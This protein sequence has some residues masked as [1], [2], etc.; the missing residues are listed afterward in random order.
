MFLLTAAVLAFMMFA[1]WFSCSV[2]W[3][4][5][6]SSRFPR[7]EVTDASDVWTFE[8]AACNWPEKT[9][10]M[11]WIDFSVASR[12][13]RTSL[14][15]LSVVESNA[16]GRRR[17]STTLISTADSPTTIAISVI[18][19]PRPLRFHSAESELSPERTLAARWPDT[20]AGTGTTGNAAPVWLGR[21]PRRCRAQHLRSEGAPCPAG[22]PSGSLPH[23]RRLAG[24][25]A[26]DRG[27]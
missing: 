18:L 1:L 10:L 16:R 14:R 26:R 19:S 12:S 11:F 21:P 3:R 4:L 20:D 25:G 13:D 2:T 22:R 5:M 23:A 6:L 27:G 17:T 15:R 9:V 24:S 7:S 8:V